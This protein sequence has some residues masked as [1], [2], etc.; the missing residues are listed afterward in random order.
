MGAR[1]S[2]VH[3]EDNSTTP[4]ALTHVVETDGP[5]KITSQRTHVSKGNNPTHVSKGC[6]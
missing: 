4:L 6:F 1:K 2:L 3:Q 5:I